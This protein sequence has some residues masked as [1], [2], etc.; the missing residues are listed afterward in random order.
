MERLSLREAA[1]RT[2]RSITTLRRY[3]RSG[4]LRAEKLPGR[5]GPEYFVLHDD[6]IALGLGAG[7]DA[8]AE[9]SNLPA[10]RS[11]AAV[12]PHA[13][14]GVPVGLFQELQ[15][16][17]EQLLVQYGMV[18][19]AGL[20]TLELR[21]ESEAGRRRV[22]ELELEVAI[23]RERHERE[24]RRLLKS[25]REAELTREAL[26]LENAALRE[27]VRGLELITRNAVTTETIE[28]KFQEVLEQARRVDALAAPG[29]RRPWIAPDSGPPTRSGT[30]H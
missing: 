10:A 7:D 9:P 25:L 4:R 24:S 11:A 15:M 3:I 8:V 29:G 26:D 20:R 1:D 17:H 23:L 6:L 21:E 28:K 16:K 19:A 13:R 14:E 5:F 27:K 30:D 22:E 12:V 18:R 2:S